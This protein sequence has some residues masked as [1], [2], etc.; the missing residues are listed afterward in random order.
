M[1]SVSNECVC[2]SD[3]RKLRES[4]CVRV[5]GHRMAAA[6]YL[7]EGDVEA[8]PRRH[9]RGVLP[10]RLAHRQVNGLENLYFY[11]RGR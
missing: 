11:Q 4:Y 9:A 2:Q 3:C 7:P 8:N 5:V 1:L 6:P 10:S